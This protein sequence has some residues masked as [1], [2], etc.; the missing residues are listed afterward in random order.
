MKK[1]LLF[2]IVTLFVGMSMNG[3]ATWQGVKK[4]ADRTWDVVAA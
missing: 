1:S 4:D 3:C 2:L